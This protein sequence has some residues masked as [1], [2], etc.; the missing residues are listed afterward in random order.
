MGSSTSKRDRERERQT[1]TATATDRQRQSDS[2]SHRDSSTAKWM[3]GSAI[4]THTRT[5]THKHA[6]IHARTHTHILALL[7]RCPPA[8]VSLSALLRREGLILRN[9]LASVW[10][11][12][13]IVTDMSLPAAPLSSLS[14]SLA[15]SS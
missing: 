14:L 1:E 15:L 7:R 2:D 6:R 3:P 4:L 8:P 13:D 9:G 5:H 11:S 10:A 12:F